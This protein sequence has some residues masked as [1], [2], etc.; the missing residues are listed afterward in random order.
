MLTTLK[1]SAALNGSAHGGGD[2]G[3]TVIRHD[4][5]SIISQ[6]R[7]TSGKSGFSGISKL[8]VMNR[9]EQQKA[10]LKNKNN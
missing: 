8:T 4:S 2:S 7:G 3:A 5:L 6:K 9:V 1:N 10:P